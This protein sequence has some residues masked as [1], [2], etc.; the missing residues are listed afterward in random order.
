MPKGGYDSIVI[1]HRRD[2]S[3]A[4]LRY[5]LPVN[6]PKFPEKQDYWGWKIEDFEL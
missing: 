1:L 4:I 3:L 5:C 6:Q 2:F